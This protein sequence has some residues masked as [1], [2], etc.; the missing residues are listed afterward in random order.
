[1]GT[2]LTVTAKGQVTLRKEVL[3]HL[4]VAPGQKVEMYLLPN[5]RL[6]CARRTGQP[7]RLALRC[8]PPAATLLTVLS[9]SKADGAAARSSPAFIAPRSD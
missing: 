2:T 9:P 8:W 1:M 3:R 7:S 4:D 6:E 5:G